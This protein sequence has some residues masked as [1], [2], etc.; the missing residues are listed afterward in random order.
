MAAV[1]AYLKV[2]KSL[3]LGSAGFQ[4][5]N[6]AVHTNFVR[7]ASGIDVDPSAGT[8]VPPR[9][10]PSRLGFVE[11]VAERGCAEGGEGVEEVEGVRARKPC[12][13]TAKGKRIPGGGP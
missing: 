10:A 4:L 12:L 11:D 3:E 1:V 5:C 9:K 7:S 8:A 6:F 2:G 13:S